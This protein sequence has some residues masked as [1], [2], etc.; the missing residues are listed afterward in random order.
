M[1][2]LI[3][4][5]CVVG[6]IYNLCKD[7]KIHNTPVIGTKK[8]ISLGHPERMRNRKAVEEILNKK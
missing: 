5:G 3:F 7:A 6:V 8:D 2:G 4:V 1:G